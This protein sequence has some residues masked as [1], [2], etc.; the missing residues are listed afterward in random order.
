MFFKKKKEEVSEPTNARILILGAGCSKCNSLESNVKKALEK[1]ESNELVGHVK[2]FADIAAYGVM[3]TPALV[4]DGQVIS[5]G[6]VLSLD[7]A[8]EMLKEVGIK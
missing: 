8:I 2:N 4:V 3:S 7:E 1:A 5:S 6:R